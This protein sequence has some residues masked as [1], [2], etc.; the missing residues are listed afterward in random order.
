LVM[1][2]VLLTMTQ[3]GVVRQQAVVLGIAFFFPFLCKGTN[4]FLFF[5]LFLSYSFCFFFSFVFVLPSL[6]LFF[7]SVF[8]FFP[9]CFLPFS[10]ICPLCFFLSF[11]F[12]FLLVLSVCLRP[13]CSSPRDPLVFIKGWGRESYPTHVQ[14]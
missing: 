7:V 6:V 1:V 8:L 11:I 10:F 14:S 13:L 3:D 4:F 5:L 9:L 2:V 12:F